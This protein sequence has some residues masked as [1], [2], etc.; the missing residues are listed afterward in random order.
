MH[1]LKVHI[2][3]KYQI[4]LLKIFQY[5]ISHIENKASFISHYI[6]KRTGIVLVYFSFAFN[7]QTYVVGK[8]C[9]LSYF[10]ASKL[11]I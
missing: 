8:Y 11:L 4:F 9:L 7:V 3:I 1:L 10:I 5:V 6:N 2:Y